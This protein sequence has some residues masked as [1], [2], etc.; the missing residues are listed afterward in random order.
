MSDAAPPPS[1]L[2]RALRVAELLWLDL[3]I[4]CPFIAGTEDLPWVLLSG[5]TLLVA[6]EGPSDA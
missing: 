2:A 6:R 5:L 4:P 1:R 3:V